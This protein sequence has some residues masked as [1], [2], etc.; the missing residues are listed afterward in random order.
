MYPLGSF[1]CGA[2]APALHRLI[3]HALRGT[4][5]RAALVGQKDQAG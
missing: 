3:R 2:A 5:R 1:D 4:I